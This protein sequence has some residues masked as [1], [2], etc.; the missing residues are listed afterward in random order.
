[1]S[2]MFDLGKAE[3]VGMRSNQEDACEYITAEIPSKVVAALADGMGGHVGGQVASQTAIAGFKDHY[4]RSGALH[5]GE[6]LYKSLIAANEALAE[7][8]RRNAALEGMGTTFV[9]AVFEDKS[10][11]WISVGDS[12]LYLCRNGE[13]TRLNADHSMAPELDR[14]ATRN[15]ITT[16]QARMNPMRHALRS[17]LMGDALQ[18]ID[19]PAEPFPLHHGDWIILASDGIETLSGAAVKGCVEQASEGGAQA[20]AERLIRAVNAAGDPAQDNTTVMAVH[21][22]LADELAD[23]Q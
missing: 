18:L 11:R 12:I 19:E 17:A 16:E 23:R 2:R 21:V 13:L 3:T 15:E 7:T 4:V 10:L 8:R 6:R 22:I 5:T 20:V 1:M 9:A 14:M